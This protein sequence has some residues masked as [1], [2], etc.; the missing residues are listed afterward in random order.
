MSKYAIEV[1][2]VTKKFRLRK[3]N[4]GIKDLLLHSFSHFNALLHPELFCA[5]NDISLAIEPGEA[6]G[7]CGPNGCG[8]TT[9]LECIGGII[10]PDTGKIRHHGRIGMMLDVGVGFCSELSGRENIVINGVLQGMSLREIRRK[11]EE[12]I[13]FSGIGKFVDQPV[14]TYSSGMVARLGFSIAT[15]MTPEILLIDEI[16]AVGDA[17]FREKSLNRMRELLGKQGTTLVFVS[18]NPHDINDF[19]SRLVTIDQGRI[20]DDRKIK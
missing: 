13:D 7:I 20:I 11:E 10:F 9:L 3:V 14:F 19:C 12:I 6:V 8:K 16:L 17:A 5:L 4:Y 1:T 2:N 18:H 15:A